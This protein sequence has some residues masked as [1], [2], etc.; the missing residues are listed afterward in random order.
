[1]DEQVRE[2]FP[3]A[4]YE[5]ELIALTFDAHKKLRGP[6]VGFEDAKPVSGQP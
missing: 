3:A 6:E 5:S 2:E 1:M 4:N